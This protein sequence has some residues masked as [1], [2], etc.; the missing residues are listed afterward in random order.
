MNLLYNDLPY[1]DL[2]ILCASLLQCVAVCCSVLQCVAVCCLLCYWLY[3]DL[4]YSDLS[5]LCASPFLNTLGYVY[6]YTIANDNNKCI[7]HLL[8]LSLSLALSA[9]PLLHPLAYVH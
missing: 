8:S 4:P 9:L 1:C 7:N 2:S 5:I 3:N 6:E